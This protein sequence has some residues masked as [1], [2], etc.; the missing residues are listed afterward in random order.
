MTDAFT[1]ATT[2]FT[3]TKFVLRHT[4]MAMG[5]ARTFKVAEKNC[6]RTRVNGRSNAGSVNSVGLCSDWLVQGE[7]CQQR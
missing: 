6:L 3:G 2:S 7:V 4:R 1:D 5:S